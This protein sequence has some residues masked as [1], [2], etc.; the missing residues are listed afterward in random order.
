[1]YSAPFVDR[2]P[3]PSGGADDV[4]VRHEAGV[5]VELAAFLELDQVAAALAVEQQCPLADLERGAHALRRRT[6]CRGRGLLGAIA[7]TCTSWPA[8]SRSVP[9]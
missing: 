1:V 5:A 2:T 7:S 6:P 4:S 8:S 3:T 9:R